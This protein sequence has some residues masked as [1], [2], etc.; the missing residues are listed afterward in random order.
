M[1][2]FEFNQ[3]PG[4]GVG[5]SLTRQI[6]MALGLRGRKGGGSD[7]LSARDRGLLMDKE[8]LQGV[9][10]DIVGGVVKENVA[11][12]TGRETRRTESAKARNANKNAAEAHT[13]SETAAQS[14]HNRGLEDRTHS[15]DTLSNAAT[16]PKFK[17][18][19]LKT[20]SA[21]FHPQ[22]KGQQM[23][24]VGGDTSSKPATEL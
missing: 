21:S 10:R 11:R 16:N 23:K 9:E 22:Q 19:N 6:G 18:I 17:A 13:R 24:G 20:G 12:T 5:G 7:G 14:A 1:A 15:F 3:A 4:K 2:E 8:H